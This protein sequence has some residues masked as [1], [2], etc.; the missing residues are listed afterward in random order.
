MVGQG[1]GPHADQTGHS[2]E[3]N[4]PAGVGVIAC[5]NP[6]DHKDPQIDT[7]TDDQDGG[8]DIEQ[9]KFNPPPSHNPE[10]NHKAGDH[11]D[12]GAEHLSRLAEKQRQK[13][14]D[15]Q[16]GGDDILNKIS[17]HGPADGLVETALGYKTGGQ[18][19]IRIFTEK[20]RHLRG[21]RNQ[22]EYPGCIAL[23]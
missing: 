1:Q 5:G 20:R 7:Q 13:H 18:R 4:G 6:A 23:G 21:V 17:D 10:H 2:P 11:R 3:K 14:Q 15:H 9:I 19:K 8:D 16:G 22:G 12:H